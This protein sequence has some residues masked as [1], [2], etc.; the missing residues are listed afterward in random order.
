M[1]YTCLTFIF[2]S[3]D[4]EATRLRSSCVCVFLLLFP[5]W[6]QTLSSFVKVP[7]ESAT[8]L[9]KWKEGAQNRA[10]TLFLFF[11][12]SLLSDHQWKGIAFTQKYLISTSG[13]KPPSFSIWG[14]H[15]SVFRS[16]LNLPL[17]FGKEI[18]LYNPLARFGDPLLGMHN[19]KLF[20]Q[21]VV[22]QMFNLSNPSCST[23]CVFAVDT[24]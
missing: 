13:K 8:L 10:L 6:P 17:R 20:C 11:A 9:F 24:T 2:M 14:L 4:H 22:M 15:R 12:C 1:N 7:V 5:F 19:L 23:L 3:D 18:F 21:L 16:R